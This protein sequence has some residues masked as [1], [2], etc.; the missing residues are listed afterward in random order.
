MTPSTFPTHNASIGKD[1]RTTL[2][3]LVVSS[4]CRL[5]VA[6]GRYAKV[7]QMVSVQ[8]ETTFAFLFIPT[9]SVIF[10]IILCSCLS[11]VHDVDPGGL[12][13]KALDMVGLLTS[14]SIGIATLTFSLTVLSIQIAAQT[15]SPR[16]LDEFL[17]DPISKISIAVNVGAFAYGYTLT[18]F[19]HTP[20]KTPYL[21]IYVLSLQMM[22]VL[23]MFVY[24][25][26]HFINGFRLESILHKAAEDSWRAALALEEASSSGYDDEELPEVPKE[27]YKVL[28]DE[29]GY[30]A[31]YKLQNLTAMAKKLDLCVRYHPNIGE[32]VAEGTLL[33]YV[34]DANTSNARTVGKVRPSLKARVKRKSE[35]SG[36]RIGG[37]NES[38]SPE[39]LDYEEFLT[40]RYLGSLIVSGV[41]ISAV[42]SGQL[43]VLMG[44]Q[45]LSDIAVKAVSAAINDPMTAIQVLDYLS[46]LFC[47][48]TQL[49]FT[50]QSERDAKGILRACAP[51]RSFA[52]LLSVLDS[53]RF[54]G[55]GDLNIMFRLL[56]FYGEVGSILRRNNDADRIS[57]VLAQLEQCLVTARKHF[58]VESTE[59]TAIQDVYNY[60]IDLMIAS[61]G[62]V[63]KEDEN[64]EI[65]LTTLETTFMEPTNAF[66][67]SLPKP[68]QQEAA[69]V[70]EQGVTMHSERS[71]T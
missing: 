47:R 18:Y 50:I 48:L 36:S 67:Q 55:G 20:E 60:S 3:T 33:A 5:E 59:Y 69:H 8:R 62:H 64:L 27:A 7:N 26:H 39:D 45:T 52:Y 53:I 1:L 44:V 24:F 70:S 15:Y 32:F 35:R 14:T 29:S 68:L 21:A 13:D 41:D 63:L 9:L 22:V 49:S 38:S 23:L 58:P 28:S 12:Q 30:V 42:R 2:K 34:W 46:T 25:I 31:G 71:N 37:Q 61:D 6:N 40:E 16:L 57:P 54:Y 43:D 10:N 65:D 19:L 56:R 66:V 17:R 51:R 11:L 4:L